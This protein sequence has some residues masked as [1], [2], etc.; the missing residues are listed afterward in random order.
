MKITIHPNA[1]EIE[2]QVFH[3][4]HAL[5]SARDQLLEFRHIPYDYS[6]PFRLT[7]Y[8]SDNEKKGNGDAE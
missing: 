4:I 7:I 2:A 5:R 3:D 8:R 1:V 6:D